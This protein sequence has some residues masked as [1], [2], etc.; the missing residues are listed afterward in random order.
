MSGRGRELW[1]Q[2]SFMIMG[3]SLCATAHHIPLNA[4]DFFS[5]YCCS[6]TNYTLLFVFSS[7]RV[8]QK[9]RAC[10]WMSIFIRIFCFFPLFV[11]QSLCFKN[12]LNWLFISVPSQLGKAYQ[13]LL[14]IRYYNS[15]LII[16]NFIN[17][18]I[19]AWK[20]TVGFLHMKMLAYCF[21]ETFWW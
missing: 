6:Y 5:H 9:M 15:L 3:I 21:V 11:K 7:S 12:C 20:N 13:R 2:C 4:K 18:L 19:A 10:A 14:W 1:G 16:N 17:R 8:Y